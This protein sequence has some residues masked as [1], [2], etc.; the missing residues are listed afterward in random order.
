MHD[1]ISLDISWKILAKTQRNYF[2]SLKNHFS[3]FFFVLVTNKEN[4]T[5]NHENDFTLLG[6]LFPLSSRIER[7]E[8]ILLRHGIFFFFFCAIFTICTLI[9]LI[10]FFISKLTASHSSVNYIECIMQCKLKRKQ[11]IYRMLITFSCGRN[12]FQIS[13]SQPKAAELRRKTRS[14]RRTLICPRVDL[15]QRQKEEEK[16]DETS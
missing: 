2:S 14:L 12:I 15:L 6:N 13:R 3:D 11:N 16:A 1:L 9:H 7:K 10:N 8:C 4:A 5:G